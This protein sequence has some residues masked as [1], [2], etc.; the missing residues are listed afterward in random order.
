[1]SF[2]GG[3]V[4]YT[5]AAGTAGAP[6]SEM[7]YG[8]SITQGAIGSAV[9]AGTWISTGAVNIISADGTTHQI[10]GGWI[11]SDGTNVTSVA[12]GNIIIP[13]GKR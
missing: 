2:A 3:G 7:R 11:T 5:T 9:P 6:A 12:A 4:V 8:L 13:V 1:M 10:T